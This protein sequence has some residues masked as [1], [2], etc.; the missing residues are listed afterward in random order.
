MI[1]IPYDFSGNL[2]LPSYSQMVQR[3]MQF[4]N[5]SNIGKDESGNY[6]MY[7][8][9]MGNLNKPTILVIS[10]MHGTEW[11][12]ALYSIRFME[13]LRDNTFRD[14]A[15][16]AK[17]LRNFHIVY[18]PVVNPYGFDR[19]SHAEGNNIGRYNVNG[20]DLNRDFNDFSQ[21]ESRNVKAVMDR[22][23]PFAFLDIH[24]FGRG[25]DGSNGLNL[26]V[27]NGQYETDKIRNLFANSL[28]RYANQS[29][30]KWDGYNQLLRGLARR[31]MRDKSNPHTPY[32]LSYIT[33][34]VRP[35][36]LSGGLDA[37]LSDQEI[38]KYG[39]GMMYLFFV[40][41]MGYFE[42]R[43]VE[44]NYDPVLSVEDGVYQTVRY[45]IWK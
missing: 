21:A 5:V 18:I 29:V 38:M 16:R 10:S 27:G 37:P 45:K 44:L 15:F 14:K 42:Q 26:I 32:T 40:T 11:M 33:E 17:L 8:I 41:S 1:R 30:V 25:M 36:Q 22:V 12:G 31:Y 3:I 43:K 13:Q 20:I 7:M 34:I 28:E 9:E 35:R 2:N 19:T 24:L 23:R 39:M 4:N 6:D